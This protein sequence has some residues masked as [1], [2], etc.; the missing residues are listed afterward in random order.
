MSAYGH[1]GSPGGRPP[2]TAGRQSSTGGHHQ[3][4]PMGMPIPGSQRRQ[5]VPPPLPP[6]RHPDMDDFAPVSQVPRW[7]W[8]FEGS[9]GKSRTSSQ[10]IEH[11]PKN[12]DQSFEE[13]RDPSQPDYRRRQNDNGA[14]ESSRDPRYN[15]SLKFDEGYHSMSVGGPQLVFFQS[16]RD[17]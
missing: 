16:M 2:H 11:F 12:W 13:D 4:A 3:L 14:I 5:E 9:F 1:D 6:P 15:L 17:F 10:K 7:Q 8:E